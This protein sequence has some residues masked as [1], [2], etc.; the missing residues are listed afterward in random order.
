MESLMSDLKMEQDHPQI[1]SFSSLISYHRNTIN[2]PDNGDS[3][4]AK[5]PMKK[6]TPFKPKQGKTDRLGP[7]WL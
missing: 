4:Y 5:L 1:T 6:P 2:C 3:R 7:E